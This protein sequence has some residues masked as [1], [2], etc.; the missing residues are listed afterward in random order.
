MGTMTHSRCGRRHGVEAEARLT[1]SA[2]ALRVAPAQ[3]SRPLTCTNAQRMKD[4][5]CEPGPSGTPGGAAAGWWIRT[6]AA[7]G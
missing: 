2:H 3:D 7:A 5:E 1:L 6:A 4:I